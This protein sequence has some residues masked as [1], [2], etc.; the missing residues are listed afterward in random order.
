[1]EEDLDIRSLPVLAASKAASHLLTLIYKLHLRC[2]GQTG[3]TVF[4]RSDDTSPSYNSSEVS[5]RVD[6]VRSSDSVESN[7]YDTESAR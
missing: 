4:S 7:Y 5:V 1:M 6:Q 3:F 2:E